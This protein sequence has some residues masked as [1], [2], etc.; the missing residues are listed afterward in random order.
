MELL[1]KI[2]LQTSRIKWNLL[3]HYKNPPSLGTG[4]VSQNW[5]FFFIASSVVLGAFTSTARKRSKLFCSSRRF[6]RLTAGLGRDSTTVSLPSLLFPFLFFFFFLELTDTNWLP[7]FGGSSSITPF[8]SRSVN[9]LPPPSSRRDLIWSG[10]SFDPLSSAILK[11]NGAHVSD[12]VSTRGLPS[13]HAQ[14]YSSIIVDDWHSS[15][16]HD[17]YKIT[18]QLLSVLNWLFCRYP[19]TCFK[20]KLTLSLMFMVVFHAVGSLGPLH[21]SCKIN[22]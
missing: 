9:S 5:Y 14:S 10:D 8:T 20:M 6:C 17:I 4:W 11:R 16:S 19:S 2:Q 18:S 13:H 15:M 22:W 21:A 7:P 1:V 12:P 3:L